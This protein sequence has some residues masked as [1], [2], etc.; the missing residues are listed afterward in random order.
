MNYTHLDFM[1]PEQAF[2]KKPFSKAPA[3]LEGGGGGGKS[4][5][6]VVERPAFTPPPAAPAVEATSTQSLAK[7]PEDEMK[8]K[9]DALKLGAKSLAIPTTTGVTGSTSVGTGSA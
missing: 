1:L 7:S 2:T 4:G 6:S 5:P 3:T 8:R 9:A